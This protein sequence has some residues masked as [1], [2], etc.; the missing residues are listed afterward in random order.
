MAFIYPIDETRDYVQK[1][2]HVKLAYGMMARI[3]SSLRTDAKKG[4]DKST[5]R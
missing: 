3:G 1:R 5:T 2:L 4:L